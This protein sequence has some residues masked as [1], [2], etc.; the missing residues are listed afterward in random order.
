M[1]DWVG[2]KNSIYKTLGATSHTK[3][4]RQQDD[5]YATD[6]AAVDY[7]LEQ[8]SPSRNIWECA[9]GE[10]HLSKRLIELGYKVFSTDLIYRGFGMG[11]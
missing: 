6:S 2:N 9:C 8:A 5:Y 1:K 3:E 7:L 11:G 4:V 10:G